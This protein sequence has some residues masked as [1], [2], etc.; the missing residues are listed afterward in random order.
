[1]RIFKTII[2][3][4]LSIFP[5][6]ISRTI[7]FVF[8]NLYFPNYKNP[9]KF[10]EIIN[11]FIVKRDNVEEIKST[12][13]KLKVRELAAD[14]K[15]LYTPRLLGIFE[16][17]KQ[18]ELV[19]NLSWVIK[20]NF[21]SGKILFGEGPINEKNRED[22]WNKI[23]WW[24][25]KV[26]VKYLNE[27]P[28]LFARKLF[29]IE[30]RINSKNFVPKDYKFFSSRNEIICIQVDSGRYKNHVRN[31]YDENWEKLDLSVLY[32]NGP[33]DE[34]PNR[35]GQM[36][37]IVK[38]ISKDFNFIRVDLYFEDDKIYLGELTPFPGSGLEKFSNSKLELKFGSFI[39]I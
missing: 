18:L 34:K 12:C 35:L 24:D 23:K 4:F 27:W 1:M 20:P 15:N 14:I 30:R 38:N 9:K 16:N 7:R 19:D 5:I 13:D 2:N 25:N 39:K 37:E 33:F 3:E 17:E 6:K 10:N 32:P 31:F 11:Y 26:Q 29:I 36:I 21:S 8:T 22:I 28:Y